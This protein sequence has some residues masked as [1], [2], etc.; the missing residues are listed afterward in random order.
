MVSMVLSRRCMYACEINLEHKYSILHEIGI[1]VLYAHSFVDIFYG[2]DFFF[3]AVNQMRVSSL[4]H[5]YLIPIIIQS[6]FIDIYHDCQHDYFFVYACMSEAS[7][8]LLDKCVHC[9]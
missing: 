7:T 3:V 5:V 4:L 1:G 6:L 8:F 9:T 2:S